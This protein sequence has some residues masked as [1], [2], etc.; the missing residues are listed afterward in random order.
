MSRE[1]KRIKQYIS[2]VTSWKFSF[3]L[4]FKLPLA[5]I[6]RLK[7]KQISNKEATVTVPFSFWNKNPFNSIYFAVLSMAGEMS[8]GILGLMHVYKTDKKISMLVVKMDSYFYKKATG[9][10][11]FICKDGDEISNAIKETLQTGEGKVVITN[12]KGYNKEGVCVSEFNVHWSF[13][14]KNK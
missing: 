1:Q 5:Y 14:A 11:K 9:K 10:I 2:K 3:F 8:T 7:I 12:S 4:M 13:K 6:A